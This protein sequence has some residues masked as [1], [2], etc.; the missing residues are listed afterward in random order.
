[1]GLYIDSQNMIPEDIK[2]ATENVE[3]ISELL[4][5]IIECAKCK[6]LW[7]PFIGITRKFVIVIDIKAYISCQISQ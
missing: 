3:N 5:A 6:K 7:V 1:M 2:N 4:V